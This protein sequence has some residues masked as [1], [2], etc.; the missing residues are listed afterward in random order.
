M[1]IAD[2]F[3]TMET[4]TSCFISLFCQMEILGNIYTL[5]LVGN[6]RCSAVEA[7]PFQLFF[8]LPENP[9]G[10]KNMGSL[11]F[12]LHNQALLFFPYWFGKCNV[13]SEM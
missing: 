9:L 4:T 11:Y 12:K 7:K 13:I 2:R 6:V 1:N 10:K 5:R 3:E 8:F